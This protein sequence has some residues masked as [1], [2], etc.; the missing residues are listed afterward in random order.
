ML[1]D[2]FDATIAERAKDAEAVMVDAVVLSTF[3][4]DDGG[5][6]V[7]VVLPL[8]VSGTGVGI[9][10]SIG[11]ISIGTIKSVRSVVEMD[12]VMGVVVVCGVAPSKVK[13]ERKAAVST[14]CGVV[15][16]KQVSAAKKI[17]SSSRRVLV[18]YP[19]GFGSLCM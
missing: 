7:C 8:C 11:T 9:S 12:S 3:V 2:E 13:G 16:R 18:V 14:V 15:E 4:R 1:S 19:L 17:Q 5:A 10:V 6:G